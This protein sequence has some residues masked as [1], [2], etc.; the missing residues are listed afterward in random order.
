MQPN[1]RNPFGSRH[2]RQ[3]AS[4]GDPLTNQQSMLLHQATLFVFGRTSLTYA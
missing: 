1:E 2:R 3:P 4:E